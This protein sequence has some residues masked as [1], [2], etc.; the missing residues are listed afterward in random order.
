MGLYSIKD[1]E[2][3]QHYKERRPP[4]IKLYRDLL[5]NYDYLTMQVASMALAPCI[6]LLA[7]ESE[8]GTVTD[9][10][11]HLVFRLH[12]P[13]AEI[14]GALQELEQR[15]FIT[16]CKQDASTAP[17]ECK[18]DATPETETET[19]TETDYRSTALTYSDDFLTFWKAYPRRIGKLAASK[20]LTRALRRTTLSVI[21][22]SLALCVK[23]EWRSR[24]P[25]FIPH[26]STWLN[27]G[28][29][30]DEPEP[31]PSGPSK[32]HLFAE[33]AAIAKMGGYPS[34]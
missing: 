19:E 30:E 6:W 34:E 14:V 29:W 31:E 15:G 11:A 2:R 16:H 27:Q 17:A 8:D 21:L 1:W 9:D 13:K 24:E 32:E 4:W 18:Q 33:A 25:E 5:D 23:G 7:S 22:S 20:S 26:P 28:R 10:L 3:F 12:R